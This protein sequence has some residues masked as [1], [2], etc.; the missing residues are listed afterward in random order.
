M[1]RNIRLFLS[2]TFV[3]LQE[4]RNY[5][6]K[7]TIPMLKRY[8]SKRDVSLS[9]V[10]LR[11]GITEADSRTG[12]VIE[13]CMDEI[14]RTRPFFIGI[15]GGRYGWQPDERFLGANGHLNNRY[16]WVTDCIKD[17]MS[18]TEMEI[19]FGVLRN[20]NPVN[21]FFFF[22]EGNEKWKETPGSDRHNRLCSLKDAISKSAEQGRCTV[23]NFSSPEELSRALYGRITAMVDRMFPEEKD[24]S[25]L[26]RIIHRQESDRERLRG[27]YNDRAHPVPSVVVLDSVWANLYSHPHHVLEVIYGIPGSGKSTRLA[28]RF[29]YDSCRILFHDMEFTAPVLH[30][31]VESDCNTGDAQLKLF[32]K[33]IELKGLDKNSP[34]LWVIDGIDHFSDNENKF[35]FSTWIRYIPDNTML[36]VST[37]DE[38]EADMLALLDHANRRPVRELSDSNVFNL[39]ERY[40]KEVGKKLND[41]Q[42]L[43]INASKLLRSPLALKI[44]LNEIIQYGDYDTLGECIDHYLQ[45]NDINQLITLV[46]E[47]LEKDFG[48]SDVQSVLQAM[49]LCEDGASVMMVEPALDHLQWIA[50]TGSLDEM[51]I[52]DGEFVKF[53][54]PAVRKAAELRYLSDELTRQSLIKRLLPRLRHLTRK[55]DYGSSEWMHYASESLR[56]MLEQKQYVRAAFWMEQHIQITDLFAKSSLLPAV[57]SPL[58]MNAFIMPRFHDRF[59]QD[60]DMGQRV[61]GMGLFDL[62][63][64]WTKGVWL[65]LSSLDLEYVRNLREQSEASL[66]KIKNDSIEDNPTNRLKIY[67]LK[68][69]I[70]AALQRE[71]EEVKSSHLLM[72]CMS[73]FEGHPLHYFFLFEQQINFLERDYCGECIRSF[74]REID[75][76]QRQSVK[77]RQPS[78]VSALSYHQLFLTLMKTEMGLMFQ[79]T[80]VDELLLPLKEI[81]NTNPSISV[82]LASWLSIR[83]E[84]ILLSEQKKSWI[85]YMSAFFFEYSATRAM[86]DQEKSIHFMHAAEEF[87]KGE[88]WEDAVRCRGSQVHTCS[89]SE[90]D[91]TYALIALDRM[92]FILREKLGKTRE[93]ISTVEHMQ[94]WQKRLS[95]EIQGYWDHWQSCITRKWALNCLIAFDFAQEDE[96][97]GFWEKAMNCF[98]QLVDEADLDYANNEVESDLCSMV[99]LLEKR[100]EL[101]AD[102]FWIIKVGQYLE[103]Y[104]EGFTLKAKLCF[105]YFNY[106]RHHFEEALHMVTKLDNKAIEDSPI[107]YTQPLLL[108]F[109]ILNAWSRPELFE[110]SFPPLM[111]E[112]AV[113]SLCELLYTHAD[114]TGRFLGT[115][116]LDTL[117]KKFELKTECHNDVLRGI[118]LPTI[119]IS[120]GNSDKA[121][122]TLDDTAR[123]A[124]RNE[125]EL[126]APILRQRSQFFSEEFN[127]SIAA[128]WICKVAQ[129]Q[130]LGNI[131]SFPITAFAADHQRTESDWEHLKEWLDTIEQESAVNN[132]ALVGNLLISHYHPAGDFEEKRKGKERLQ[133]DFEIM[134]KLFGSWLKCTVTLYDTPCTLG[135]SLARNLDRFFDSFDDMHNSYAFQRWL[136]LY[137]S[138]GVKPNRQILDR[139]YGEEG[140]TLED[141][142]NQLLDHLIGYSIE[143][144]QGQVMMGLKALHLSEEEKYEEAATLFASLNPETWTAFEHLDYEIQG[145]LY[146]AYID[147][148]LSLP[149]GAVEAYSQFAKYRTCAEQYNSFLPIWG[150]LYYTKLLLLQGLEAD[151]RMRFKEYVSEHT[152]SS[153]E[154]HTVQLD[155]RISFE[156]WASMSQESHL[157]K[158]YKGYAFK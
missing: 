123:D 151:A 34:I 36:I 7:K 64:Q 148:L 130:G 54:V 80:T 94:I 49:L 21:A 157:Y 15:V 16:P 83:G 52:I 8:C 99:S 63:V 142:Y 33:L 79:K 150:E 46:F 139:I 1:N 145:V 62:S 14:R 104:G 66:L 117:K 40:L 50:I 153:L 126:V 55:S 85:H 137:K 119:Y 48:K 47:R 19:Q 111:P 82:R 30:S 154:Y 6:V 71:N 26:M 74:E 146:L 118:V 86:N 113:R 27:I 17:G 57:Q 152:R 105:A 72:E 41:R 93:A 89:L 78:L 68:L 127:W 98:S 11:W 147:C 120:E 144:E 133:G 155:R 29:A 158:K 53:A 121:I 3:D 132:C 25:P 23:D 135:E 76:L 88:Y 56:I 69:L 149:D 131:E 5:L 100:S 112:G 136:N 39:I 134:A 67:Y 141:E 95:T 81:V 91:V 9:I 43:H 12:R 75:A 61:N 97:V 106:L 102:D 70:V 114:Y 4:E 38:K 44:F 109:D 18:I 108:A 87:E 77:S 31:S 32:W 90:E 138:I 65:V 156:D 45:A 128:T 116:L 107:S 92:E 51:T 84:V 10:D 115:P 122:S 2:S 143:V 24:T 129:E 20:E 140:K 35:L 58:L 110:T 13:L 103:N 101:P 37:S 125:A 124:I 96:K 59:G 42:I 22:G 60:L 73:G 28:N